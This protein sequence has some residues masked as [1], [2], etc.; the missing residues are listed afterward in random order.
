MRAV[1]AL[2]GWDE[3]GRA[4]VLEHRGAVEGHAQ[5]VR[6]EVR[7][8]AVP[9]GRA[10]RS[11]H[12][13]PVRVASERGGLDERRRR[14]AERDRPRLL[15]GRGMAHDDLQHDG[16]ALPVRDD[17]AGEVGAH[18][19]EGPGEQCVV[20]S[21]ALALGAMGEEDDRIVRRAVPVDRDPV[22]RPL[23]G[24]PEK[25]VSLAL[26][27]RVVGRDDREHRREPRVDHPRALCHPADGEAVV[28]GQRGLRAGVGREDGLGRRRT[29]AGRECDG[30]LVN[31]CEQLP[32]RKPRSDHTG[33]EHHDLCGPQPERRRSVG[34]G[35]R[36]ILLA[37]PTR[38]CV[39]DARV[40][41]DG[42]RLGLGEV[43][44]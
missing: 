33:R 3:P 41:D 9:R 20:G 29:A 31:A 7:E 30:G 21:I 23:D 39:R 6:V 37:R 8:T 36:S 26:G 32:H 27:E 35:L 28:R 22:E 14:H 11:E 43:P 34:G 1:G 2:E 5:P 19:L 12:A 17:L 24:G 10:G 40:H 4:A 42:L 18:V 16:R 15:V 13:A 25:R 44:A 38:G